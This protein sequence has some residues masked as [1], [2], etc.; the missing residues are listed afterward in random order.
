MSAHDAG[1]G[2]QRTQG[3]SKNGNEEEERGILRNAGLKVDMFV[4]VTMKA[5]SSM[6]EDCRNALEVFLTE[7]EN[8]VECTI[9]TVFVFSHHGG[10]LFIVTATAHASVK[11]WTRGSV[12]KIYRKIVGQPLRTRGGIDI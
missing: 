9:D 1:K 3:R 5:R 11:L 8:A 6:D 2:R 4:L 7:A 12:R 10:N